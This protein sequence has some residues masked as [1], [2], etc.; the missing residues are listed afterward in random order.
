MD[1]GAGRLGATTTAGPG[2]GFAGAAG[3]R[4]HAPTRQDARTSETARMRGHYHR[5]AITMRRKHHEHHATARTGWLRAAVLGSNDAIVSTASL[6]IG[7][8]A[9]EANRTATL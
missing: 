3:A 7:V 4:P 5:T 9:S 2:V 8:A 6:M 1:G